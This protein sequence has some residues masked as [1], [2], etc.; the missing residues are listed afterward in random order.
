MLKRAS[1]R[2]SGNRRREKTRLVNRICF[3]QD[4]EEEKKTP[5]QVSSSLR[6]AV[7]VALSAFFLVFL[8]L[9][10]SVCPSN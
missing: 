5:S 8:S 2:L 3:F 7:F 4:S 9:I 10:P 1:F 6:R